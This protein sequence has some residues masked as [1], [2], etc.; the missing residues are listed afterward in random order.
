ML[1]TKIPML[2]PLCLTL[3]SAAACGPTPESVAEDLCM[4]FTECYPGE[5]VEVDGMSYVEYCTKY[6]VEYFQELEETISSSCSD[7]F[8][9]F[10][11]CAVD[12]ITC[13][14][15]PTEPLCQ[16]EEAA[17]EDQCGSFDDLEPVPEE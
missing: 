15:E 11:A 12:S 14:A 7:A 2:A 9:E 5:N 6:Y 10:F 13:G 1:K 17:V 16:T 3:T 8:V 4:K